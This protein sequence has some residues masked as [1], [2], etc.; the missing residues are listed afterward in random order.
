MVKPILKW[1]GGK[2]QLLDEIY[3]HFP[4][5]FNSYHEPMMGGGA[6]FFNLEPA[7]GT[8][9]D[10]NPRL[11]NFY[12]IVR[13]KPRE[14]IEISKTFR[15][16]KSAPDSEGDFSQTNR[17]GKKVEY[18]FYQQRELFNRRPNGEYFNQIQEAALFLYLNRTCYNG[19]YRENLSGEFNVPIGRYK[20]PDW[21][22]EQRI[23]E[24]SKV[25]KN[26]KI[27]NKGFDYILK[28]A[29]PGDL[30]YFDPPYVPM[31]K[32]ASFTDYN[33][34]GFDNKKQK[35]LLKVA[36][37]LDRKDVYLIISNS[38]IMYDFYKNEG[39]FVDYLQAIRSINSDPDKRGEIAEII[40][41]N[42]PPN[43][44]RGLKQKKINSF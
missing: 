36:K 43:K 11:I 18:Y 14:L 23:L 1:A 44:R 40:A 39:F 17:K 21:I 12:M 20:N 26:V 28:A 19:L 22:R 15:N 32:T 16:P 10:L 7:N 6:L 4:K 29:E 33:A 27:Y 5:S 2:G 30:V 37:K 34:E 25:L 8:I 3:L 38:G 24:A 41:T 9:N 13:D 31:S 42:I 35:K